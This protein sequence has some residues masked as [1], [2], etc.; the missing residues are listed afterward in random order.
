MSSEKN[1]YNSDNLEQSLPEKDLSAE[2]S[3]EIPVE[4]IDD[5]H[6]EKEQN[7]MNKASKIILYVI[8]SVIIVL[9][10][11]VLARNLFFNKGNS[12]STSSANSS[13]VSSEAA[14]NA[15]EIIKEQYILGNLSDGYELSEQSVSNTRTVL[16]Y[17]NDNNEI[18]FTQSTIKGYEPEYDVSDSDIVISKF[19][20]GDGQDYTAY[21]INDKCYIVWTTDEYTFEIITTMKKSE[22]I[23]FIF[24]V[25]KA[26]ASSSES[27]S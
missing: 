19:S 13:S 14:A 21:Q 7:R 26:E 15:P 24:N 10:L 5:D 8:S 18:V 16:T 9:C 3:E 4:I 6:D 22:S 17:K 25:Q 1:E 2:I 23:P 12:D 27:E 11:I 20:R